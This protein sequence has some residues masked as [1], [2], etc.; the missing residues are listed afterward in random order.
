MSK[1]ILL[2]DKSDLVGVED[3]IPNAYMLGAMEKSD[4]VPV[5]DIK[6]LSTK[7]SKTTSTWTYV[8]NIMSV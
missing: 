4:H 5:N 7:F 3:Y 6:V 2:K 8:E 1:S